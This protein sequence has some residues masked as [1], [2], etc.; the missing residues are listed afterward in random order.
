MANLFRKAADG[1]GRTVQLTDEL[2]RQ[3]A[4]DWS[5][6]GQFLTFTRN[7][8]GFGTDIH[9]LP[10]GADRK[11]YLFWQTKVSEAHSQ[12][13]PGTPARWIAYSSDEVGGRREIFVTEF[14]PGQMAG[15][16][17][18]VS[19]DGGTMPRW[20]ADGSE[21]YY[22]TLDG[23]IMAVDVS[24]EG[25]T[26]RLGSPRRLFETQPPTLRTNA[27]QFD[28]DPR[29]QGFLLVEPSE[30][31]TFQPLTFVSNWLQAASR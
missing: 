8:L 26:L 16:R 22:W 31:L 4:M 13:R 2:S 28:V 18:Q 23:R 9:I 30:Q 21:L 10:A 14:T 6:D 15:A 7:S 25:A 1:T 24:V 3:H 29:G 12:F 27:I 19:V 11:P 5:T 17:W 20:R